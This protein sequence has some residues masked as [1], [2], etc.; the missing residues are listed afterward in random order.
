MGHSSGGACVSYALEHFQDKISKAIFLCGTM[1]A[2][3]QKPFDVFA[4]EVCIHLKT[5]YW[6]K[7]C[8][9]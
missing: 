4:E 3:G 7:S 5:A 9:I 2:D 1:V 6:I 8:S